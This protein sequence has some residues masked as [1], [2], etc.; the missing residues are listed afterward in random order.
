LKNQAKWIL[1]EP[2]ALS[3]LLK[4]DENNGMEIK[5]VAKK[6]IKPWYSLL[7]NGGVVTSNDAKGVTEIIKL[8]FDN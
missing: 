1:Q 7:F 4:P 8:K 6:F 5:T 3:W 2:Q